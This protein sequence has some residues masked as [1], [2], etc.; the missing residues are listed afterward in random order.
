MAYASL[1]GLPPQHDY[2]YLLG[3]LFYALFST[4][5]NGPSAYVGDLLARR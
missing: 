1:A 4:R 3:G 2:C 5:S